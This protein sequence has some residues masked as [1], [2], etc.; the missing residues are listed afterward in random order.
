MSSGRDEDNEV[1]ISHPLPWLSPGVIHIKS[2]L[3]EAALKEESSET[4][5]DKSGRI[6]FYLS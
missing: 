2:K 5:E 3:N 6:S 4:S 1:I